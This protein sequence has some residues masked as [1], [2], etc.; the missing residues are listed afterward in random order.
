MVVRLVTQVKRRN[1]PEMFTHVQPHAHAVARLTRLFAG[2][3]IRRI[4]SDGPT[5]E[6]IEYGALMHD[7]G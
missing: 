5:L 6:E 1:Q 4:T 2:T 7:V 3:F